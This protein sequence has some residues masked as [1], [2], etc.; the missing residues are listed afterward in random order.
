MRLNLQYSLNDTS[1]QGLYLTPAGTPID[2]M[3][4]APA[5]SRLQYKIAHYKPACR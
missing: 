1:L 3:P 2:F 5:G 4:S